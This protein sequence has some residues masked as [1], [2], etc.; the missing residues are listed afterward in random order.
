MGATD[1][2]HEGQWSWCYKKNDTKPMGSMTSLFVP[3]QPDNWENLEHCANTVD[4]ATFGM[5]DLKCDHQ[6]SLLP[7]ICE[8]HFIA[9]HLPG[10]FKLT[11]VP[12]VIILVKILGKHWNLLNFRLLI[13]GKLHFHNA[14]Q[15]KIA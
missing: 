4:I 11:S 15:K 2:C 8:V 7:F 5:N 6:A 9:L 1:N 10:I 14:L 13:I 12:Y 3:P